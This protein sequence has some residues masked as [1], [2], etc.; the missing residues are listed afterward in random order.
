MSCLTLH[1]PYLTLLYL[2]SYLT[3][4][5]VLQ[6]LNLPYHTLRYPTTLLNILDYH[7]LTYV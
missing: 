5:Y 4:P 3:L 6:Y 2:T 7:T 1:L